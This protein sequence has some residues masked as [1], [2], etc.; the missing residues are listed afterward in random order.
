[1]DYLTLN[2]CLEEELLKIVIE[3]SDS[4]NENRLR[5]IPVVDNSTKM[6]LMY[7]VKTSDLHAYCSIVYGSL[8]GKTVSDAGNIE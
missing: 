6:N 7:V 5:F 4:E 8:E 2:D 1:M 3:N